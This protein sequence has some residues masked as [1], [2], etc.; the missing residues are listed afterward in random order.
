MYL[1]EKQLKQVAECAD[2][3][4]AKYFLQEGS[5]SIMIEVREPHAVHIFLSM[6]TACIVL[7]LHLFNIF[8]DSREQNC[9]HGDFQKVSRNEGIQS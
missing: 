7:L 2:M 8:P 4:L 1:T 9:H 3:I 5:P 6:V